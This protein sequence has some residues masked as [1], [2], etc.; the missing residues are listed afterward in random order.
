[1]A[2]RSAKILQIPHFSTAPGGF[3]ERIT[4]FSQVITYEPNEYILRE[5]VENNKIFWLVKGSCQCIKMLPFVKKTITENYAGKKVQVIPLEVGK[6]KLEKDDE[7][8]Y[9]FAT[10]YEIEPGFNFPEIPVPNGSSLTNEVF[11]VNKKEYSEQ[12]AKEDPSDMNSK[13]A[14][15]IVAKTKVEVICV[16]RSDYTSIAS[17]DMI[18]TII[19]S[20]NIYR[21][22]ISQLQESYLEGRKWNQY[23]KKVMSDVVSKNK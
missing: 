13:A 15:S 22:P 10:I 1:M 19:N 21:I 20:K 4:P 7:F 9:E 23:K 3:V 5:G 16:N 8:M 12:L 6:T 2:S 14:V 11:Y 17:T 18:L